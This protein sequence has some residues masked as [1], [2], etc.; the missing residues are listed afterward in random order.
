MPTHFYYRKTCYCLLDPADVVPW[1][2]KNQIEEQTRHLRP[3]I[4]ALQ[5]RFVAHGVGV[6]ATEIRRAAPI[7]RRCMQEVDMLNLLVLKK[8]SSL[9]QARE[10]FPFYRLN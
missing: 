1:R 7:P 9:V 3:A 2:H 8:I 4:G 5:F 6:L 10:P